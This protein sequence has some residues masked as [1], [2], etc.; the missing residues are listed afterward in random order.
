MVVVNACCP[1]TAIELDD[2]TILSRASRGRQ[3]YKTWGGAALRPP[4]GSSAPDVGPAAKQIS[5][6]YM[7]VSVRMSVSCPVIECPRPAAGPADCGARIPP[8]TTIYKLWSSL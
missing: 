2:W 6:D 5:C 3:R 8:D 1:E 4:G 7:S